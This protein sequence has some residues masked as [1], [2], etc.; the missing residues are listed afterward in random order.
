MRRTAAEIAAAAVYEIYPNVELWGGGET[1]TGFYYD[2]SC[3][4]PVQISLIEEKMRQIVRERRPIRIL[5]MVSF[6]AG[7]LLKKEGHAARAEEL[8]EGL[9]EIVQIG[10]F[11]DLSPGPHL[12]NTAELA[13][14]KIS[15]EVLPDQGLRINGWCHASKDEL[16][17]F[18]KKVEQYTEHP[19]LGE[20]MGLWKGEI[21]LPRGLERRQLLIDCLKEHWFGS[22]LEVASPLEGDR[23]ARHRTLGKPKIAEVWTH[24]EAGMQISFFGRPESE[25]I[26]SLQS[27]GKTLT[28][29]GFDHSTVPSGVGGVDFLIEDGLGRKW[30]VVQLKRTTK[31]GALAVDF[32]FTAA[33]ERIL[34]LLLEHNL[35]MVER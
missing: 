1:S 2:F 26:S 24:P 16:K 7:E 29:L 17:K 28:I 34:A 21:W 11:H 5:E 35:Q 12:K 22:A 23:T 6:S 3:P 15:V 27:I 13:A 14:F 9:V 20:K 10:A 4:H 8:E 32:H 25:M 31:E 30:P 18:L 19:R 33:V